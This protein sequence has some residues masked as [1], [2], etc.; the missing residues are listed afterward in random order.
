[1]LVVLAD[2]YREEEVE[3]ETRVVLSI[4]PSLAPLKVAVFPLVKKD[5]LPEIATKLHEGLRKA[6]IP[7]FYDAA[8]SIGRRYRRQDEAGT[9]WCV[10]VDGQTT[11]DDTVTI[12][13]RD[14]LEQIRISS[15]GVLPWIR[16]RLTPGD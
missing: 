11:D 15:E 16:E 1:V 3:G 14:S 8:G 9:P 6:A 2:A 13:D 5:G 4:D 12:R 10:T 7:S